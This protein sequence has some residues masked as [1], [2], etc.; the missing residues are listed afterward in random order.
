MDGYLHHLVSTEASFG[1]RVLS[2]PASALRLRHSGRDSLSN[3]QL[4][5]C[6]L[7]RLFRRR[8]KNTSKPRVTGL[9]V[10]NS[11]LNSPHKWPVTRKML[12]FDDVIMVSVCPCVLAST[13][14]LLHDNLS[15]VQA[16]II[17]FG[18]AVQNTL[19]KNT[20]VDDLDVKV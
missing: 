16:T 2:F 8:S 17:N 20:G 12:P 13:T 9:C 4:H 7:N 11:P 19:V 10:G 18:Q 5:H 1:L 6:L 15:P 14:S 3:H